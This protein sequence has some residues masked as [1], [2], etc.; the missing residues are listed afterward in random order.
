MNIVVYDDDGTGG[1]PGTELFKKT[2]T[3]LPTG[4]QT[5]GI[6]GVVVNSGDFYI[7]IEKTASTQGIIVDLDNTTQRGYYHN[8]S[9]WMLSG[10]TPY[11]R[12]NVRGTEY[13]TGF[14]RVNNVLGIRVA[15]PSAGFYNISVSGYNVPQGPQPY[16]LVVS[17]GTGCSD[18]SQCD[19]GNPCTDD[20]CDPASG[21][22]Y[23]NDDTSTCD[24]GINCT[25]NACQ[26]GVCVAT[27]D[28]SAC[29]NG[30][31]C[32]GQEVCDVVQGCMSATQ[33]SC[34]PGT[35]CDEGDDV[36]R[37]VLTVQTRCLLGAKRIPW[38]FE[39]KGKWLILHT[40]ESL[41]FSSS[42]STV[43]FLGPQGVS[44]GVSLHPARKSFQFW[45]FIFVPVIIEKGAATGEWTIKIRT[46]L[47]AGSPAVE[48]IQSTFTLW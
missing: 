41:N 48:Y 24:D 16:A 3:Y 4:F 13:T 19:D 11:I 18:S 44:T 47:N 10:N 38:L 17:G 29:D 12:A 45:R 42:F 40:K 20:A 1:L 39:Q 14:D 26:A 6:E 22:V 30:Q 31:Y 33:E 2:L 7:A 27:P 23:T 5:I 32:D 15:A 37:E 8:V 9:Q 28:N 34:S 43:E 36:C 21:C 35:E 25:V 46:E